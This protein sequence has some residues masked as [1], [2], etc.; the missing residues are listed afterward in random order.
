MVQ[1]Y[2]LVVEVASLAEGHSIK[3]SYNSRALG[4]RAAKKAG[5]SI[6]DIVKR[7]VRS[8][9]DADIAACI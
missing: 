5:R 1:P 6:G 3:A 9:V 7:M 2:G 8:D 4:E